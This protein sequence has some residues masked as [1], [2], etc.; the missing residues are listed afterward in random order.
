MMAV[1]LPVLIVA[2]IL[3]FAVGG[4]FVVGP[5][6]DRHPWVKALLDSFAAMVPGYA[7]PPAGPDADITPEYLAQV[8]G[9]DKNP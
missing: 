4:V 3:V 7:T 2:G 6:Y 5:A 9:W 1:L 8:P